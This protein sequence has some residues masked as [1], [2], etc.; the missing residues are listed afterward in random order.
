MPAMPSMGMAEM[1]VSVDLA[2]SGSDYVGKANIPTAGPWNVN[3][4]VVKENRVIASEK[5]KLVA[6]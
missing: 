1:R 3:V 2:W 5:T 4:Q 6:K